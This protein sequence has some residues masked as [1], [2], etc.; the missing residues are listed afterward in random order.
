MFKTLF[1][2][3]KRKN[4][5]FYETRFGVDDKIKLEPNNVSNKDIFFSKQI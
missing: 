2:E 3:A 4:F 1:D 5:K